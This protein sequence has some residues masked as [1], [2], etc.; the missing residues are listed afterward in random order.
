MFSNT[1]Y[2]ATV[3]DY[4]HT[5]SAFRNNTTSKTSTYYL[6]TPAPPSSTTG[7]SPTPN[8]YIPAPGIPT[9]ITKIWEDLSEPG[10][11]G[12]IISGLFTFVVIG[13]FILYLKRKQA[14]PPATPA[15]PVQEVQTPGAQ[16]PGTHYLPCTAHATGGEEQQQQPRPVVYEVSA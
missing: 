3:T 9:T 11:A 13:L 16:T 12:I 15:P 5:T 7:S 2:N 8:P 4:R 1:R 10:R 14:A 6:L